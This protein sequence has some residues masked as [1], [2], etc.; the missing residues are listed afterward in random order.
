MCILVGN[1]QVLLKRKIHD[2][3]G[4]P[5]SNRDYSMR[6]SG[7]YARIF[8]IRSIP[9]LQAGG[10]PEYIVLYLGILWYPI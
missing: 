2:V 4:P 5:P 6:D 9:P 7:D 8:Y 1:P 3:G 10:P